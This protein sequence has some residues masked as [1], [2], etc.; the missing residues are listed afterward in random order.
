MN[1]ML[2]KVIDI[3]K[4]ASALMTS[5]HFT[6]MEKGGRENLVTSS[7]I[8]VQHFLTERLAAL[9]PGCGFLC[10]EEDFRDLEE[11]YVWIIDPIDGTANY[12]RGIADCC[13]SVALARKGALQLGVVYSPARGELYSAELG[14]GAQCNG[15]P[16]H[17]SDRPLADGLFCTAMS[18]YCKEYAKTCSDIIY[19][20]YM[21]SNDT[22]RWGSAAIELCLLASGVVELYFEMRLQPWDYAAAMLIL[23]EAGGRI[24]S[25]NGLPPSLE[26]QSLVVAAT[27]PDSRGALLAVVHCHLPDGVPYQ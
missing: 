5:D 15:H 25:W 26:K 12:S 24:A 23:H 20:I 27:R 8:A 2:Q 16:I 18:T 19:D 10:E 1:A 6:V 14:K 3:V 21:Q 17:V 22:R 9:L 7:D 4:E 11:E 13:I